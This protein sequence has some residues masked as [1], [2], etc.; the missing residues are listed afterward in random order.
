MA[1]IVCFLVGLCFGSFVNALVWRLKKKRNFVSERSECTRCHHV[2]AWYDL[3][4]VLSWLALRGTCR[5]CHKKIDD[6]PLTELG[7]AVVFAVSFVFWPFGTGS[8]GLVLLGLWLIAVVF[9]AALFVY[10]LR[11]MLLPD[12][13]TKPLI[14]LGFVWAVLFRVLVLGQGPWQ[15]VAELAL[16]L[17]SVAGLYAVLYRVSQGAWVGFGDV[18]LGAFMGL[19]LGWELGLL[20]VVLANAIASL[21]VLP[22]LAMGK[23]TRTSRVPFGPFLIVATVLALLFGRAMLGWYVGL[24]FGQAFS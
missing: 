14:A 13:L 7:V 20:A 8:V 17:L 1:T 9:L 22:G 15:I 6:S 5:Y 10:D 18:K 4:P 3:L 19:I 23:L 21:C 2:L 16:G 24:V 11:W 12:V